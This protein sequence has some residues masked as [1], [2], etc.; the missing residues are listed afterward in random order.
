MKIIF[1]LVRPVAKEWY[2]HE[3]CNMKKCRF[4]LIELL[5]VIAIIAILAAMLLPA[6]SSVKERVKATNCL[7]NL[8]QISFGGV[9]RY[10]SD[11]N[12]VLQPSYGNGVWIEMYSD[13]NYLPKNSW[14]LVTCPSRG[15]GVDTNYNRTYG[16]RQDGTGIH[17]AAHLSRHN[18]T[19]TYNG[20]AID[21]N[22]L[23][24]K[25]IKHPS[26]WFYA[27]DSAMRT[28]FDRRNYS[29]ISM[30]S[31]DYTGFF[32]AAHSKRINAAFID[33]HVGV[34]TGQDFFAS[35]TRSYEYRQRVHY[36]DHNLMVQYGSIPYN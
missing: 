5:V 25:R 2:E 21:I 11:Y 18:T 10:L 8:K 31:A 29:L 24:T 3:Q 19:F 27:G 28:Q 7:S 16:A 33:G 20:S 1:K 26:D 14:K 4:T 12:D 9:I 17:A 13:L 35:G 36:L 30:S 34:L 23:H 6:L 32:Y 15:Q 22:F